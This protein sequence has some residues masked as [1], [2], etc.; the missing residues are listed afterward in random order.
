MG[1]V[2]RITRTEKNWI[3]ANKDGMKRFHMTYT[4]P[5]QNYIIAKL[6]HHVWERFTWRIYRF[7][8]K[9]MKPSDDWTYIPLTNRQ[10]IRCDYLHFKNRIVLKE[11]FDV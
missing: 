4:Q 1:N 11:D 3:S 7:I 2:M 10:D 5:L 9:R 6:Y 8:E